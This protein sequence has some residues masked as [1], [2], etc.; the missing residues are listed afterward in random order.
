MLN[1]VDLV[2]LQTY[3]AKTICLFEIWF[4]PR[5]FDMMTRL[6]IHLVDELEICGLVG[7]M[8]CYPMETYLLVLKKIEE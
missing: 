8:W 6:I 4:P 7:A 1:L 2:V 5:F 3:V